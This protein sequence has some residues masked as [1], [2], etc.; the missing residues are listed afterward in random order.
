MRLNH[1][2]GMAL[3]R[4]LSASIEAT[5]AILMLRFGRVD[6]AMQ[7]NGVLALVGPAVLLTTSAIG[8]AG[9]AGT[10]APGKVAMIMVGVVL[11]FMGSR[12]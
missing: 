5:A 3:V 7:L 6:A 4:M 11:I 2:L 9:L 12:G 10:L 1:V 8:I